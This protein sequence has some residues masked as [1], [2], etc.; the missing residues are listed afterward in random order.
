MTDISGASLNYQRTL[1][2]G[3]L[4]AKANES[5][6][7]TDPIHSP[8]RTIHDT[9]EISEDGTKIINLGR[10]GE[11][12]DALPDAALDRKAFDTALAKSLEDINRISALFGGVLDELA[13]PRR[14]VSSE[15][16][17]TTKLTD[18][19]EDIVNLGQTREIV[20]RLRSGAV[21]DQDFIAYLET[22]GRQINQITSL[23]HE[24]LRTA[25]DRS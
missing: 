16:S 18:G 19:G 2:G 9:V 4:P 15:F 21:N 12:A 20:E 8:E 1:N 14:A 17:D 22:S 10:S 23:L 3:Q 6:K 11:L 13:H 25:F 7:K 5:A 24:T